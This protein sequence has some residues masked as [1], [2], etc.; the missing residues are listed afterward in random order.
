MGTSPPTASTKAKGRALPGKTND[1]VAKPQWAIVFLPDPFCWN[2]QKKVH[3]HVRANNN[4]TTAKEKSRV[5]D[6]VGAQPS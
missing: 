3:R 5:A 2:E 6:I 1:P 4:S